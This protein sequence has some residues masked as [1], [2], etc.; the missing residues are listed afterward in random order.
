MIKV[1]R[2][3]SECVFPAVAQW[4]GHS[5]WTRV[6]GWVVDVERDWKDIWVIGVKEKRECKFYS[7][8]QFTYQRLS[9]LK[10]IFLYNLLLWKAFFSSWFGYIGLSKK[11]QIT[12]HLI[13]VI[14]TWKYN[15]ICKKKKKKKSL[16]KK[17]IRSHSSLQVKS[18][19]TA[20]K[21][22]MRTC[23]FFLKF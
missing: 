17:I 2:W 13:S 7:T 23:F 10:I 14:F 3:M 18:A 9:D 12:T 20:K 19:L 6:K 16:S 8:P 11:K 22:K 4:S 21:K 15:F 1:L 5:Q